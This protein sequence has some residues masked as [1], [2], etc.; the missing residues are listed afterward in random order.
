MLGSN[1]ISINKS[2][3]KTVAVK[4]PNHAAF[5]NSFSAGIFVEETLASA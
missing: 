2:L 3:S 5:V 1:K 4:Y